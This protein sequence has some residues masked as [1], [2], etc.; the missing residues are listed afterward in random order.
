MGPRG[1]IDGAGAGSGAT[2]AAAGVDGGDLGGECAGV[3]A[4]GWGD[5]GLAGA[6]S[7]GAPFTN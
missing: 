4:G 3:G 2:V 6:V 5:T 7:G 1:I